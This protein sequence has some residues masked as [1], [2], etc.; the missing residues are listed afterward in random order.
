M[1]GFAPGVTHNRLANM[2]ISMMKWSQSLPRFQGDRTPA[3]DPLSPCT[4]GER[5]KG[6][7]HFRASGTVPAQSAPHPD[8][9]PGSPGR[10]GK[11][12]MRSPIASVAVGILV[13]GLFS[14][15]L[16]QDAATVDDSGKLA[17]VVEGHS[18]PSA[19]TKPSFAEAGKVKDL[20]VKPGDQ[21]HVGQLLATLDSDLD[22][23]DFKLKKIAADSTAGIEYA[24]AES[25]AKKLIYDNLNRAML[26]KASNASE[27]DEAKLA[28]DQAVIKITA[29][30]EEQ[31]KNQAELEKQRIKIEKMNLIS[32]MDGIVREIKAHPG[33]IADPA[34]PDGAMTLVSINPL[35]VDIHVKSSQAA[36]LKLGQTLAACYVNE[37]DKWFTG[38]II[39]FDPIV[40]AQV[41]NQPVRLDVKNDDGKPAGWMVRVRLPWPA[42]TVVNAADH[43]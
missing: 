24:K 31:Q 15:A 27:L 23:A 18:E 39:F 36:K 21:V 19:T 16:A 28:W 38:T 25:A 2:E 33:E 12:K 3:Y 13:L 35:W 4:H 30:N 22:Q 1:F 9:L 34:K 14:L 17:A 37:P 32:P 29:A 42:E 40:N 11:K 5:A 43:K 26:T 10:G 7:G 8:P 6:E 20:L 41:D